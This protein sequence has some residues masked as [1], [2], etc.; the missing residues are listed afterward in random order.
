M[1]LTIF[2]V[3]HFETSDF[4]RDNEPYDLSG[5]KRPLHFDEDGVRAPDEIKKSRLLHG[6]DFGEGSCSVLR[7]VLFLPELFC[8]R[9]C[10]AS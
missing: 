1:E 4:K 6:P 8:S 3:A 5:S 10:S 2:L 7:A 9:K